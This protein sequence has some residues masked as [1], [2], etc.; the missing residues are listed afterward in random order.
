[1]TIKVSSLLAIA[2]IWAATITAVVIEPDSWWAVIFAVLATGTIGV[3]AWRRL[4]WSRLIGIAGIWA[5]TG[6]AMAHDSDSTWMSIFAFLSTGAVVM[7]ILKRNDTLGGFAIAAAWGG[8]ATLAMANGDA[9]TG[10]MAFLTAGALANGRN[11]TQRLVSIAAWAV[12]AAIGV[13]EPALSWL[14][15][16]AFVATVVAGM[17]GF[18]PPRGIEWDLFDRKRRDDDAIEGRWTAL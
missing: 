14:A 10:V 9:W 4:G 12:V 3:Q 5:A 13:A 15:V 11:P 6:S 17:G 1:V 7:S 16:F 2:A 8:A 18:G